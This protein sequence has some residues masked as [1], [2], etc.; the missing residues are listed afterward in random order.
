[1][2]NMRKYTTLLQWISIAFGFFMFLFL[3]ARWILGIVGIIWNLKSPLD[4]YL[5]VCYTNDSWSW[6]GQASTMPLMY[7][8]LGLMV[9]SVA[10]GILWAGISAFNRLIKQIQVG[11]VFSSRVVQLL[12]K[13][14]RIALCWALYNPVRT[15]LLSAIT[16]FYKGPGNRVISLTISTADLTNIAIFLCFILIT[17][18]MQEG[19]KLKQEQDLTI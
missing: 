16:T 4:F 8:V 6:L 1:M 11:N 5:K 12:H 15:T 14:S 3:G 10:L 13:L 18:L 2:N 9:D 19:N 7:R 17:A